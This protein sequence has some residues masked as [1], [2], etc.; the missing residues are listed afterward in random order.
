MVWT[1]E[2]GPLSRT[3]IN[4]VSRRVPPEHS[5]YQWLGAGE[6]ATIITVNS[7]QMPSLSVEENHFRT[8]YECVCIYFNI[9]GA[10]SRIW[11]YFRV[12]QIGGLLYRLPFCA[13][14]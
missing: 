9:N 3:V 8:S 11:N 10:F 12:K 4:G 1:T 14:I 13:S 5:N 6:H 7:P 2:R